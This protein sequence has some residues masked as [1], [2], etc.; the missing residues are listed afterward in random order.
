MSQSQFSVAQLDAQSAVFK[1]AYERGEISRTQYQYASQVQAK[2][3][4]E[5]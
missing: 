1:A 4:A 2:N 5:Y 3:R